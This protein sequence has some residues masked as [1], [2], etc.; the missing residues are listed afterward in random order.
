MAQQLTDSKIRATKAQGKP[1][2]LADGDGLW[3]HVLPSGRRFWRFRFTYK[4]RESMVSLGRYPEVPLGRAREKATEHRRQLAER[5][6]PAAAKRAARTAEASTFQSV[7]TEWLEKQPFAGIT[8]AKAE[9]IFALLTPFIGAIPVKDLTAPEIL[10]ALRRI[11]ARGKIE[12]AHRALQRA[13]QV[14]RYAVASGYAA[15]NP[16]RDLR[17]ALKPLVVRHHPSIK[18]PVRLGA[19]L[20]AIEGYDGE[21]TTRAA[22]RLL[23][24]VFV[25][26]GELRG[27]EWREFNLEAAEWRIP[28]ARMKMHREHIVPL[29]PQAV[30]ILTELQAIT[31]SGKLVFPSARTRER[32]ISDNTLNAGLRRIGY[33]GDEMV[34]HGFRSIASTLLNE[35]GYNRDWIERQLAHVEGNSVRE[36]YNAAEY[37]PSRR[38]MMRGWASYL[39]GLRSG[40]N[41]VPLKR[42][43]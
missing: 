19:L 29:A 15:S 8:R 25:R 20:R 21:P 33:T 14:M 28:A 12:T 43:A 7:A 23:P 30:S 17:D 11:E 5:I 24:Y 39:D 36:A 40:A 35:Q 10:A 4:G 3:L 42:P 1:Y 32:P 34:A 18:D 16:A 2:K 38:K 13:S 37:L 41:V 27:A 31:G 22:L 6:D 26:P 9:W